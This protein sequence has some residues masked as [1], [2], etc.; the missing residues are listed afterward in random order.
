MSAEGYPEKGP[1][2]YRRLVAD[3]VRSGYFW[4]LCHPVEEAWATMTDPRGHVVIPVWPAEAQAAAMATG[5]WSELRPMRV[6]VK[7]FLAHE[8]AGLEADGV[9]IAAH[10]TP[11]RS[12]AAIRTSHFARALRE[13]MKLERAP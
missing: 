5:P 11:T 12:G 8:V 9:L 3:A 6:P 4:V 13:A 1:D 10:P 2:R 7:D